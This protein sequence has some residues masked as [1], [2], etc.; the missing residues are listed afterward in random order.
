MYRQSL[1]A[2]G[3]N[4]KRYVHDYFV[5]NDGASGRDGSLITL[6][7]RQRPCPVSCSVHSEIPGLKF[8]VFYVR[9]EVF[10]AVTEECRLLGYKTQF[11]PHR[12]HIT[13]LLQSPAR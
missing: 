5:V 3:T 4:Q 13:S 10:T 11:V 9:F 12:R 2:V 7:K 1:H 6:N 8:T